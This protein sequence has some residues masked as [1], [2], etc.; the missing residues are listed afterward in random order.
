MSRAE[1]IEHLKLQ[2]AKLR[3]MLFGRMSER[4]AIQI[5]QLE[6]HLEEM[7]A[8]QAVLDAAS[9]VQSTSSRSGRKPLPDHLPREVILHELAGDC[10]MECGGQLRKFGEDVS[11]QIELHPGELQGSPPCAAQVFLPEL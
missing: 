8:V 10:C 6:L 1:H 7:E 4:I 2:L 5:D 9:P 3:Q 11:E